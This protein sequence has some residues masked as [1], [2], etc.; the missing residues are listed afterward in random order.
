MKW[1]GIERNR[2]RVGVEVGT[3]IRNK[4]RKVKVVVII[5]HYHLVYLRI[6]LISMKK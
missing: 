6:V 2:R 1:I 4:G 5:N 3:K